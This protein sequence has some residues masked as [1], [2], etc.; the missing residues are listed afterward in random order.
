[1]WRTV[2][3]KGEV[4][5]FL[6]QSRTDTKAALKLLCKLLKKQGFVPTQ[7]VIEK[8]KYY[9]KAFQILS[10]TA[11]KLI[12]KDLIITLRIYIFR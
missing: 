10:V 12:A 9:Y 2:N 3:N 8:L 4:L 7:I 11:N 5:D 6:V 1:L